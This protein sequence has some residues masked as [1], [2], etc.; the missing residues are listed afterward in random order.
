MTNQKWNEL[1]ERAAIENSAQLIRF[2]QHGQITEHDAAELACKHARNLV[3][4]MQFYFRNPQPRGQP[5]PLDPS[6]NGTTYS[7]P[8]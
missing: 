3:N 4:Q 8:I 5:D 7:G 2:V 1:F 6:S